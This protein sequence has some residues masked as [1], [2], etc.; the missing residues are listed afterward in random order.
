MRVRSMRSMSVLYPVTIRRLELG[1]V[2]TTDAL[3]D[4]LH[5]RFREV[6]PPPR[7]VALIGLPQHRNVG[8]HII[9]MAQRRWLQRAGYQIVYEADPRS[10][11]DRAMEGAVRDDAFIAFS[12]GG[13]IGDLWPTFRLLLEQVLDRF[14]HVPVV[15]LPQSV[16]FDD[17]RQEEQWRRAVGTHPDVRI[18]VRDHQ[19]LER[20]S[21]WDALVVLAPDAAFALDRLRVPSARQP[22]VKLL[23]RDKESDTPTVDASVD[24]NVPGSGLV[25]GGF[26]LSGKVARRFPRLAPVHW[27]ASD[28]RSWLEI[29]RGLRVIGSGQVLITDRLHAHIAAVLAGRPNV[30]LDNSYG[31]NRA[32]FETWT[33]QVPFA[34]WADSLSEAE[35]IA[36][37]LRQ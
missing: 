19:S 36:H 4:E 3:R 25:Q 20:A 13:S 15:V 27:R 30:V 33:H 1:R 32:F 9:W 18:I 17:L 22:T 8:D 24:W 21:S 14:A 6:L 10:Y 12:G 2:T 28:V 29:R 5:R 37:S 31:K 16:H 7:P 34:W 11:S 26:R 35:E 23:R